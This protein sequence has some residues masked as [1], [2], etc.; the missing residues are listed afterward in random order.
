MYGDR[1]TSLLPSSNSEAYRDGAFV[2]A[3]RRCAVYHIRRMRTEAKATKNIDNYIMFSRLRK[4]DVHY[5][6]HPSDTF[7]RHSGVAQREGRR[8]DM[9]LN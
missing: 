7:I 4:L 1:S 6:R 5:R 8:R 2:R 9:P 3:Q